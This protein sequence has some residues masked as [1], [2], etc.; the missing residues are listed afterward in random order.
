MSLP[1]NDVI[2]QA[3]PL[4]LGQE[5]SGYVTQLDQSLAAIHRCMDDVYELTIGGTAVGTGLNTHPQFAEEMARELA[6]ETQLPFKSMR[7]KF[8]GLSSHNA[9][10][11]LSSSLKTLACSLMKVANDIRY[12]A[13]G[14]RCGF[15]ELILPENEPGE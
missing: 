10:V 15:G 7:N 3:V 8:A 9:E 2:P 13:S 1:S 14:P 5:L 4:T 12:L 11:M 6:N